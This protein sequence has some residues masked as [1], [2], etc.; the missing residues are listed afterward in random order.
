SPLCLAAWI[1]MARLSFT[2]ACPIYSCK[3]FGR[4]L[5]S[6][7]VSTAVSSSVTS[8]SANLLPP[9]GLSYLFEHKADQFPG[10]NLPAQDFQ[11]LQQ[12]GPHFLFLITQTLQPQ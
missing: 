6:I 1:K 8:L 2:L 3:V 10:R 7:S 11:S 5:L 9:S 12:I 4:K